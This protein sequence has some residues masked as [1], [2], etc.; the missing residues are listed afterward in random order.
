[1]DAIIGILFYYTWTRLLGSST[2]EITVAVFSMGYKNAN[3]GVKIIFIY[4]IVIFFLSGNLLENII[5]YI[6]DGEKNNR[7]GKI[8]NICHL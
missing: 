4:V 1:M 6:R 8:N 7:D 2:Q 3:V 5:D